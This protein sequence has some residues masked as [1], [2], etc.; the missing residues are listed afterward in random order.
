MK[1][2]TIV[3]YIGWAAG[4]IGILMLLA[5]VICFFTGNEFLGVKYF[6]NYF[7]VANTFFFMGIFL[8][9][10]T[11]CFCCCNCKDDKCCTDEGKEK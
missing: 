2:C 8:M 10:S 3:N 6:Q 11:R 5:G 7:M 1:I 9:V 4:I